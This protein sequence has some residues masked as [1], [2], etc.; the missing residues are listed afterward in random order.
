MGLEGARPKERRDTGEAG[1]PRQRGFGG[2]GSVLV[3]FWCMSSPSLF[4]YSYINSG[5]NESTGQATVFTTASALHG[6]AEYLLGAVV[7][8]IHLLCGVIV[9]CLLPIY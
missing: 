4:S 9:L 5:C 3:E 2:L 1:L 6:F 8:L 7:P